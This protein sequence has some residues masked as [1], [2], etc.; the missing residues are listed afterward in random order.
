MY[1]THIDA[2]RKRGILMSLVGERRDNICKSII[3]KPGRQNDYRRFTSEKE[4]IVGTA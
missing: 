4:K 2:G 3:G 1:K